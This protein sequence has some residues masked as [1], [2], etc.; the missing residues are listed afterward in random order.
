[1]PRAR[2]KWLCRRGMREL[3][4]VLEAWLAQRYDGATIKQKTAFCD[5]LER[6]DPEIFDYLTDRAHAET[7]ELRELIDVLKHLHQ[8]ADG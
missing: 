4:L 8:H 5:L 2:L 6:P 7:P 3:D 1:M